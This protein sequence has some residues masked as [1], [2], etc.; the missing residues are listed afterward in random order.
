MS[1][2]IKKIEVPVIRKR[3]DD[4]HKGD[5]GRVVIAGGDNGMLGAVLLAG[6]AAL[7]CGSGRVHILSTDQH[8][9]QPALQTPELMS[10]VF[11]AHNTK[12]MLAANAIAIG[13]GLGLTHWGEA[14]FEEVTLVGKPLVI[15]ADALTF[16]AKSPI[17]SDNADWIVTPHP[18]EAARLLDCDSRDI[19]ADRLTA[20]R[21][22]ARDRNV[23]CVLK[24]A[25]TLVAD[26]AGTVAV[27]DLGNPGMA[28]AGMGDVLT[29]MIA[30]FIG[31]GLSLRSAA[32]T[33][34]W[35]HA[36]SADMIVRNLSHNALLASDVVEQL[37]VSFNELQTR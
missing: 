10:A 9:D 33:A 32:E 36:Y 12:L 29:G 7:R 2:T 5:Y 28:T 37:A 22:I 13:P 6:R 14:L 27:C 20:A 30:S 8:L 19:Q 31:Q 23:L 1:N 17:R 18:G 15:D 26:P 25:R 24:G 16:L 35:L 21:Q 11:E 34:V 4:S 3:C